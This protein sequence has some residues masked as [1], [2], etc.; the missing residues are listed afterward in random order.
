MKA[1]VDVVIKRTQLQHIYW[2]TRILVTTTTHASNSSLRLELGPFP[3]T[4]HVV[5]THG[6][7]KTMRQEKKMNRNFDWAAVDM[8]PPQKS[9]AS[10]RLAGII[11]QK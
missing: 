1:D 3:E 8:I 4:L 11:G 7:S 6:Q 5:G 2:L 10:S 9:V